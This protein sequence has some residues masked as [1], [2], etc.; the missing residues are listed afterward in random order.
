MWKTKREL[1]CLSWDYNHTGVWISFS[2]LCH[3]F[4]LYSVHSFYISLQNFKNYKIVT[5]T[6]VNSCWE[7]LT[8][9]SDFLKTSLTPNMVLSSHTAIEAGVYQYWS[10]SSVILLPPPLQWQFGSKAWYSLRPFL[11]SCCSQNLPLWLHWPTAECSPASCWVVSITP[12]R[13]HTTDVPD[14]HSPAPSAR[15]VWAPLTLL[16]VSESWVRPVMVQRWVLNKRVGT[17]N[18]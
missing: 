8:M 7:P 18:F 12:G 6:Q 9:R 5:K 3:S 17:L 1:Y 10:S 15:A 11:P 16:P 13:A 4:R 2:F 14:V